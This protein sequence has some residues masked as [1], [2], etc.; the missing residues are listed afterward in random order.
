M[1]RRPKRYRPSPERL[2]ARDLPSALGA[3]ASPARGATS[4]SPESRA[5]TAEVRTGTDTASRAPATRGQQTA[6]PS[7]VSESL[8]QSL[9]AQL[10]GPVTTTQSIKIGNTV[11][12][13]GTYQ[14]PQPTRAE[15]RRE[16]FWLTFPGTYSVGPPRFSN[17]SATIHIFS[18]GNAT[19]SN[20]FLKGR[21]QIILFPPADPTAQ[22]TKLDP[23]AG[24]TAGLATIFPS[25]F[26]QSS[27]NLFLD[28]TTQ[29][30]YAS[31][32]SGGPS[33]PDLPDIP[34]NDPADLDHGLPS[35]IYFLFDTAGAG[36]Y[37]VPTFAVTP[38]VQRV[39][40]P[41]T[42]QY[43]TP[44]PVPSNAAG[45]V[46]Y[47]TNGLVGGGVGIVDITYFPAR[48]PNAGA[49]QSGK[50]V[51]RLQGVINMPGGVLSAIA[52]DIN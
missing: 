25:N 47:A 46:G 36:V 22:P 44:Q 13:P 35:K 29:V 18:D 14:T 32:N 17:Q 19:F 3:G 11:F 40:D 24:Q 9:A 37:T 52:K 16:T 50:V 42:G 51:V 5:R 49:I 6:T 12:P 26:L 23:V 38:A 30:N 7:W 8:L 1:D 10:H 28:L 45:A 27:D 21:T 20:Q 15:I 41:S 34:S 43:S 4:G 33:Y 48:H 31:T 2:E 39:L